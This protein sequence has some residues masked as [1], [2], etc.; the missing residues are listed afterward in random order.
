MAGVTRYKVDLDFTTLYRWMVFQIKYRD[1]CMVIPIR[2]GPS[3][4]RSC[5]S[6]L[7][8]DQSASPECGVPVEYSLRMRIYES[9]FHTPY[10][11]ERT[12]A[13]PTTLI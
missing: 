9:N 2:L 10:F 1:L 13:Q 6:R 5:C 12:V 11:Q 7:D 8:Q 3:F 4:Y